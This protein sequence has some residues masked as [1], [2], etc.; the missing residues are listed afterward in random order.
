MFIHRWTDKQ[1]AR[2]FPGGPGVKT[3]CS[4]HKGHKVNPGLGKFW[5]LR[6]AAK[7]KKMQYIQTMEYYSATEEM[8]LSGY[9]KVWRSLKCV[10]LSERSQPEKTTH[11]MIPTVRHYV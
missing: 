4:Q 1:T 2:D 10:I 11:C 9:K 8:S 6:G 7:K 3:L 5:V